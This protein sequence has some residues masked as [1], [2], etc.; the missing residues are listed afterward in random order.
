VED[1][2]AVALEEGAPLLASNIEALA[3]TCDIEANEL[4]LASNLATVTSVSP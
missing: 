3:A 2:L 4:N 1:L